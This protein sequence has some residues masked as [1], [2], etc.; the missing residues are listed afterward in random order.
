M[1]IWKARYDTL[2][3]PKKVIMSTIFFYGPEL[4]EVGKNKMGVGSETTYE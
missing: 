4:E 3:N 1:Q 2:V